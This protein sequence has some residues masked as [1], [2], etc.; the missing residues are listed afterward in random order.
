MRP[1]GATLVLAAAIAAL[2]A[3]TAN[4]QEWRTVRSS[5]QLRD[6]SEHEV[7]VRYGAGRLSIVPA[8]T[9]VLYALEM[10]YDEG[11]TAPRVDYDAA[12]RVLRMGVEMEQVR[13]HNPGADDNLS[14]LLLQLSPKVPVSLDIEAGATRTALELGGLAVRSL[15]LSSGASETT[16]SFEAPN[17]TRMRRL[18]VRVGA[19]GLTIDGLGNATVRDVRVSGGVGNVTLDLSGEWREPEMELDLQL[20]LGG[21]RVAVPEDVGIRVEMSRFLAGFAHPGL[22]RR[23]GAFYSENWESA[24]R[25]L[26]VRA[27]TALGGLTI[28][29]TSP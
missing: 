27:E 19:A 6:T 10:T 20:A 29:R 2:G 25:R 16:V 21:A 18:E 24:T 12:S 4:A 28:V 11:S 5:R 13:L 14:E 26:R 9:P 3:A 7:R 17:P 8:S 23:G 15:S 1:A 22:V